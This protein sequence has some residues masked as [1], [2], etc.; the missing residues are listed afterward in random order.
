VFKNLSFHLA[1]NEEVARSLLF[2]GR[3]NR[4]VAETPMNKRSSRSHA[5]FTIY[6]TSKPKDSPVT[7]QSKLHLVD[8]AGSERVAKSKVKGSVLQEAKH[9][10]LSL[11]YLEHVIVALQKGSKSPKRNTKLSGNY[12]PYRNSL[13]TTVLRDSLGG[14]C[15][16]AMIATISIEET[17][18]WESISTCRFAQRVACIANPLR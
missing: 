14:N 8:L 12:V 6:L 1:A 10:N 11:H 2:Q 5:V 9:I 16:T 3:T 15:M 17:N 7:V 13:L 4:K 18:V